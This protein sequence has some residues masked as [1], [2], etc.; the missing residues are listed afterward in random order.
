MDIEGVI[1]SLDP[2]G[3]WNVMEAV[4][5]QEAFA[6]SYGLNGSTLE[7]NTRTIPEMLQLRKPFR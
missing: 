2:Q 6:S 1:W 5:R 3:L 7:R 4:L